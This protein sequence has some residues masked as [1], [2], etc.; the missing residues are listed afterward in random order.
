MYLSDLPARV[1]ETVI[2]DLSSLRGRCAVVRKMS[3]SEAG[4]AIVLNCGTRAS[5]ISRE[6]KGFSIDRVSACKIVLIVSSVQVPKLFS[7]SNCN[8]RGDIRYL[9]RAWVSRILRRQG[10]PPSRLE[11]VSYQKVRQ[12]P[13]CYKVETTYDVHPRS[14][15]NFAS[16]AGTFCVPR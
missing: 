8:G 12:R 14:A 2:A 10:I 5:L 7:L 4:N 6:L 1:P 9:G 11:Y 16:A 15:T 3:E 13:L